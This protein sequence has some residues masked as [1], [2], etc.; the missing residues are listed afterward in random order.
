M[1]KA[2]LKWIFALLLVAILGYYGFTFSIREGYGAIVT[3]FG[4]ITL[5]SDEAG[6]YGKLPW[7]FDQ[8]I[9]LDLRVQMLDSGYTETLTRDKRNIILQT[10]MVWQIE[11]LSLFYKSIGDMDVASNYLNDLLANAKNGVMGGYDLSSLVS[12][13]ETLIQLNE[14]ELALLE[15]VATPALE[16]YGISVQQVSVKRLALPE[17]NM[18]S[19]YDQMT[20]ERQKY[21][22]TLLS[23]GERD[24]EMIKSSADTEVAQIL[25]EAQTEAAQIDADTEKQVSEIYANAYEQNP[26]LFTILQQ[27]SALE[28][29]VSTSTVMV[30]ESSESP[31]Q[32]LL[33]EDEV[34]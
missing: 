4:E 30:M 12:T 25:A 24:A 7:P 5:E 3:R 33:Q 16:N 11:D 13:D 34:E 9:S 19:V 20:T 10:Y 2:I 15:A 29:S 21:V 31:F 8:V 6:L 18:Q 14:I 27:L 32:V 23:E 17:V 1:M 28:S 22:T 26:E